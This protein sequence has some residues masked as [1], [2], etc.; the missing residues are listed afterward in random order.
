MI[1]MLSIIM[2]NQKNCC[3]IKNVAFRGQRNGQRGQ[4]SALRAFRDVH[5]YPEVA[6]W[7]NRISRVVHYVNPY[8]HATTD[9]AGLIQ[10]RSVTI[11]LRNGT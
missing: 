11:L 3:V 8:E 10:T 1:L 9:T 2:V 4:R 5:V 6:S 7:L